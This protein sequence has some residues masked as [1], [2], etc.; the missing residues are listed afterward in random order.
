MTRIAVRIS[1]ADLRAMCERLR[2]ER[3]DLDG[4]ASV[5]VGADEA[6]SVW[7]RRASSGAVYV[8]CGAHVSTSAGLRAIADHLTAL[9]A[10]HDALVAEL[11]ALGEAQARQRDGGGGSVGEEG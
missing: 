2:P 9:L 1:A 3:L 4:D 8:G 7:A 11:R 5:P 6:V 10:Y